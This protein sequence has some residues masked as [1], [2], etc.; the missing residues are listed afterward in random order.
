MNPAPFPPESPSSGEV[1][2]ALS[3]I[4][5]ESHTSF[6][7]VPL[8]TLDEYDLRSPQR[9]RLLPLVL[10]LATCFFTYAAGTYHWLPTVFGLQIDPVHGEYW[11]LSQTFKQLVANWQDGL[12]YMSCVMAV[13]LAHE[14]GHFLMTVRYR[15]PA[16]YP[17][18]IPMPLMLTG[19]M[20]AVIGMEGFRANRRQMFDIGLAGPWAGLVLTVPLVWI[21]IKTAHPVAPAHGELIFGDPLLAK[22]LIKWLRPDILAA[23]PGLII[24]NPIYMAGWVGM[25][26]TGLNMLPVSQLDGGH[27][28]YSLFLRRSLIIARVFLLCAIGFI[29]I[30]GQV[31]WTLMVVI[32]TLIGVD[33]PR[34]AD[35]S[36][37]IGKV[38]AIVGTL[39]LVLPILCFTPFR[40]YTT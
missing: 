38:R 29:V 3:A 35:D 21:G 24:R 31:G 5:E 8:R 20:G 9:R 28:I 39:S 15:V 2:S 23:G 19:T 14:M 30:T 36:V 33:H 25:F 37:P 32:I 18:F 10:F 4:S 11:N 22:L 7:P 13:L 1:L 26:V 12:I 27:V 16:S 6:P 17:I 34:T 40:L